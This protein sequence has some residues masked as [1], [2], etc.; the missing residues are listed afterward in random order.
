MEIVAALANGPTPHSSPGASIWWRTHQLT[1][2]AI[3]VIATAVAWQIKESYRGRASIWIFVL[4]G[5]LSAVAG[6]IRGH[7]VFIEKT[8]RPRLGSERR[9]TAMIV[10]TVDLLMALALGIAR[11]ALV[12]EP[13]TAAAAFGSDS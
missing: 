4:I 10:T 3:Y 6:I 12:T 5:I 9:R 2:M 1:V 11:G 8:N 7:L 13:A